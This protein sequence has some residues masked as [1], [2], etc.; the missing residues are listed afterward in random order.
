MNTFLTVFSGLV[1][2]WCCWYN[3]KQLRFIN[4]Q[5]KQL[6]GKDEEVIKAYKK[7]KR[8]LITCLV[9]CLMAAMFYS[10][11]LLLKFD[12][13]LKKVFHKDTIELVEEIK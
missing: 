9:I 13:K 3:C 1:I 8:T 10:G 7:T 5:C 4:K 6:D 2:L 12:T 11:S